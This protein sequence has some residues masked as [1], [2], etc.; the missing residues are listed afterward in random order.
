VSELA[1]GGVTLH[2][3]VDGEGEP[4]TV[5][6]HGLSNSCRE[7]AA[8]TPMFSGTKVR[9]CFRGHGHSSSPES[10][11][12]FADLATDLAVVADTYGAEVAVGTSMGAGALCHLLA[13]DPKR[14]RRLVMLLPAGVDQRFRE[15]EILLRTARMIE[16]KTK[17]EAI[18]TILSDPDRVAN[19]R[20]NPWLRPFD[21][22]MLQGLNP[23]GVPRAIR[24][25]VQDTV[26]TDREALRKV[27]APTLLICRHGDIIHPAEVGELLNEL[28][29]DS[30]LLMFGDGADMYNSLPMIVMR[31]REFLEG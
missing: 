15:P 26:V 31:V 13:G 7:L 3:E 2:V 20:E 16:G 19:Y 21:E 17:E 27:E 9:F 10:G 1:N 8:L 22:A 5:L 4:V 12:T 23:V 29:P 30:E 24:E 18:E 14:F 28:I 11:Y 6:A 25:I